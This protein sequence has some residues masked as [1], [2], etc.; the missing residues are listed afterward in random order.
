[1]RSFAVALT[2]LCAAGVAEA[3]TLTLEE[4]SRDPN[5][6]GHVVSPRGYDSAR[7]TV[8]NNGR[9]D[10]RIV[11]N[12]GDMLESTNPSEQNLIFGNGMSLRVGPG[13][14]AA[15]TVGT[16]CINPDRRSPSMGLTFV[17]RPNDAGLQ[18]F[19]RSNGGGGPRGLPAR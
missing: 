12:V 11:G 7:G 6:E 14:T 8:R 13:E 4:A 5:L 18:A 19:V 2:V 15:T 3:R 1:M 17:P 9:D 16:Y 10:V